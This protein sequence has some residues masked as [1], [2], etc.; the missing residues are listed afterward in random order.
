V[1]DDRQAWFMDNGQHRYRIR[2]IGAGVSPAPNR[3][4]RVSLDDSR[5]HDRHLISGLAGGSITNPPLVSIRH[6]IVIGYDSANRYLRA[7]RLDEH[8]RSACCGKRPL[9]APAT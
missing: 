6:R 4:I 2:M 5:D 9:A 7:W 3:L 1:L 8:R